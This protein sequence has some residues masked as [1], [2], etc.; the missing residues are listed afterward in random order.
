MSAGLF[1]ASEPRGEQDG[2]E[3][4][5]TTMTLPG[6]EHGELSRATGL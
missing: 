4:Q 1:L 6:P 3:P 5:V 2:S